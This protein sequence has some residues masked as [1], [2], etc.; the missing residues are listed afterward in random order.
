VTPGQT[1][2]HGA[3]HLIGDVQR[4]G[5]LSAAAVVDRYTEIIDRATRDASLRL[6]PLP[7]NERGAGWMVDSAARIAEACLSLVDT[8]AELFA[9]RAK[10][11][12]VV[13]E[14]E[15][16]VLPPTSSGFSS[17]TSLWVHNPTPSSTGAIELHMTSLI[18]S[19]GVSI[20]V[21]SVSFSPERLD[22]VDPGIAREV[23][24]RVDVPADQP[25]GHYHGLVLISAAPFEP[26]AL[27]LDVDG[28]ER[29]RHD[30]DQ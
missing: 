1:G 2:G 6:P 11:D 9:S 23:R 12:T 21:A 28:R 26:I 15:R 29:A 20:P 10:P 22:V 7:A 18:S 19:N 16:L 5:L 27:H 25:A 8:T 30:G 13:P 17:E 24:L 14:M 4:F 3:Q